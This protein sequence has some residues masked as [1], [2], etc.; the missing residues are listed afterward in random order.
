[1]KLT[2]NVERVNSETKRQE[3]TTGLLMQVLR[4][5]RRCCFKLR[6]FGLWRRVVLW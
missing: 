2:S 5:L 3:I 4:L 6:S 1:M